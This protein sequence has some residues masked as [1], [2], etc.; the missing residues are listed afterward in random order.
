MHG[1]YLFGHE[2]AGEFVFALGAAFE[3]LDVAGDAEFEGLVV[4]GFEVEVG[5]IF[6]CAPVTA[7]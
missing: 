7:P 5:D 4:A 3:E 6:E 1:L 2:A